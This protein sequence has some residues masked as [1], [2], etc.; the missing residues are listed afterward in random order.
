MRGVPRRNTCSSM[1]NLT[2]LSV[3]HCDFLGTAFL[4]TDAQLVNR[5]STVFLTAFNS[6]KF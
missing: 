4:T 1:A 3:L 5:F 2:A 6:N